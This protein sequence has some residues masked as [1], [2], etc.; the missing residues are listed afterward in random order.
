[1]KMS[2]GGVAE[3]G[4]N[5]ISSMETHAPNRF[6]TEKVFQIN[7]S[8][9]SPANDRHFTS[10]FNVVNESRPV[11]IPTESN[12][13]F[14]TK[15]QVRS[16][17]ERHHDGY[18]S[19]ADG[20]QSH[21]G[22]YQTHSDGDKD[23]RVVRGNIL[24]KNT[25][26]QNLD[27]YNDNINLFDQA[28]NMTKEN[29]LYHSDEDIYKRYEREKEQERAQ[30]QRIQNSL[31]ND[32]TFETVDR[33]TKCKEGQFYF[34]MA[35]PHPITKLKVRQGTCLNRSCPGLPLLVYWNVV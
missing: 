35:H 27:E 4:F 6:K 26:D 14:A 18:Q 33:F 29:P 34:N 30:N 3:D 24:I 21:S 17:F 22:G 9:P 11:H 31:N 23:M 28:F 8:A 10:K 7:G 2:S 20:F 19:H 16:D 1:M 12:Q 15:Y 32:I 25:L 13:T 5:N